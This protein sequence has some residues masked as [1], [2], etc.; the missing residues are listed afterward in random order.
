VARTFRNPGFPTFPPEAVDLILVRH[1][2]SAHW[3][4]GEPMEMLSGQGDPPLSEV[5]LDQARA[6]ADRLGNL[7]VDAIYTSTLRRTQ[8]TA[9]PFAAATG[10]EPVA[11]DALR[12]IHLGDWEGG[13]YRKHGSE[14]HPLFWEHVRQRR[15]DVIPG[16]E[17][18][19]DFRARV[20]DAIETIAADHPG[21]RVMVVAHGGVIDMVLAIA[22]DLERSLVLGVDQSSITRVVVMGDIW[23]VRQVNDTSH[24]GDPLQRWVLQEPP[25]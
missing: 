13:G 18:D 9:A 1:G 11:L 6:L 4:E 8:Q 23:R 15:W 22:L 5:G 20:R 12:E 7:R 10:I 25:T 3:V 19:E 16:A 21:Q 14:G 17:S 24:L 2:E